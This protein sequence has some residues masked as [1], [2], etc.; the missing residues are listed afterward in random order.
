MLNIHFYFF[1]FLLLHWKNVNTL[2]ATPFTKMPYLLDVILLFVTKSVSQ[3]C[4]VTFSVARTMVVA[5]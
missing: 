1:E 2:L 3:S 4:I 5:S